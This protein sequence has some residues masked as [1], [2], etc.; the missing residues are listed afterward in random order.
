[1]YRVLGSEGLLSGCVK[2]HG[3]GLPLTDARNDA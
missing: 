2:A 3:R 1:M